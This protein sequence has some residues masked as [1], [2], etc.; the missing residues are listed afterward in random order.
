MVTRL[1]KIVEADVMVNVDD[2]VR[3]KVQTINI[4]LNAAHEEL[5]TLAELRYLLIRQNPF[6]S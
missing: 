6:L 1:V 5:D 2:D 4:K 3:G